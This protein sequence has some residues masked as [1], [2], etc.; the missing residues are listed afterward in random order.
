[1]NANEYMR[2]LDEDATVGC[3][4]LVKVKETGQ[5]YT[6]QDKVMIDLPDLEVKVSTKEIHCTIDGN[7]GG[8]K[9]MITL[10]N[11]G[12]KSHL[13]LSILKLHLKFVKLF[14]YQ[15]LWT[16]LQVCGSKRLSCHVRRTS[17]SDCF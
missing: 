1:M 17:I 10:V 14:S 16:R 6:A 11:G 8:L 12:P 2:N 7:I 3:S 15:C 13:N 4:C 5:V 9:R